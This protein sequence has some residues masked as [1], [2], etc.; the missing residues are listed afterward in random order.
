MAERT[1]A[2]VLA[3]LQDELAKQEAARQLF[4]PEQAPEREFEYGAML[5]YGDRGQLPVDMTMDRILGEGALLQGLVT[6]G[7]DLF[8]G[9]RREVLDPA[10]VTYEDLPDQFNP[11][12]GR[13]EPRIEE[14]ITPGR[15]GPVEKSFKFSPAY[16][17]I[18]S[19]AQ[20]VEDML[21]DPSK[22]Q[23]AL[24]M[25]KQFP[26]ILGKQIDLSVQS[27]LQGER[28]VDPATGMSGFPSDALLAPI[29]ALG[30]GRAVT[31][32]PDGE[33]L[34][35]FGGKSSRTGSVQ[36]PEY[37]SQVFGEG[38][39]ETLVSKNTGVFIGL[40]KQPRVFWDQ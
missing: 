31:T 39:P 32:L 5:D 25:I 22:R 33:V 13:F 11:R 7:M 35:V 30:A 40:D 37:E 1:A 26:E 20:F 9:E 24:Q 6:G 27:A 34:G 16:R 28:V 18:T 17:G 4:E 14:T 3:M 36:I 12:T 23:E 2:E 29:A 38:L 21:R 15:Y 19:A 8:T 10:T